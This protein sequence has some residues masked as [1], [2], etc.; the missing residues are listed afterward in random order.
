MFSA[1]LS[2]LKKTAESHT[3][4]IAPLAEQ[5]D[6]DCAWP[7]HSMKAF[8]A[9]GLLSLQVPEALSGYDQGLLAMSVLAKTIAKACPSFALSFGMRCAGTAVIAAK[10]DKSSDGLLSAQDCP[11]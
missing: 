4:E 11:Q 6:Y 7:A 9:A 8:A 3:V 2:E 1:R 10:N 5:I